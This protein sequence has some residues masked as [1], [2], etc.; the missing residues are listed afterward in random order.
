M[1]VSK[2]YF[3]KSLVS[4]GQSFSRDNLFTYLMV[5]I[6]I[7][8]QFKKSNKLKENGFI[9][10]FLIIIYKNSFSP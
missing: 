10:N 7:F 4:W 9:N 6:S 3:L 1:N 8:R 5:K 2:Y